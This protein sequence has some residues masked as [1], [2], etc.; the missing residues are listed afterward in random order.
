MCIPYM[1]RDI[2]VAV[3]IG[4]VLGSALAIFSINLPNI[5]KQDNKSPV[6]NILQSPT[7]P[8]ISNVEE[9]TS[10]TVTIPSENQI[11]PEENIQV[12]GKYIAGRTILIETKDEVKATKVASSGDFDEKIHI[13]EGAN[14]IYVTAYDNNQEPRTQMITV[15]YTPEKL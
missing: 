4:F 2:V 12:A 8:P 6:Q 11:F 10:L 1:N 13:V 3:G 7:S 5:L 9:E 14:D 15:F